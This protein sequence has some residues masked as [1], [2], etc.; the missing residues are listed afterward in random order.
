MASAYFVDPRIP[1]H[2]LDALLVTLQK[3]EKDYSAIKC[4]RTFRELTPAAIGV[5]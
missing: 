1:D 2:R 4:T 3:T 5:T